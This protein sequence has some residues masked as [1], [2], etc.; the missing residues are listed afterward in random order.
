MAKIKNRKRKGSD[1]SK[2][3]VAVRRLMEDMCDARKIS[4]REACRQA[5]LPKNFVYGR[6][7]LTLMTVH[8]FFRHI[9]A[10]PIEKYKLLDI[11][12]G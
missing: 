9:E 1:R 11:I 10:T 12:A 8:R 6:G 2:M 7:G 5:G 3:G 4:F